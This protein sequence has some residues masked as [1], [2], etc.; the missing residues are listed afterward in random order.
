ML[1]PLVLDCLKPTF[2]RFG[3]HPSA[4]PISDRGSKHGPRCGAELSIPGDALPSAERAFLAASLT[5]ISEGDCCHVCA[6]PI[7]VMRFRSLRS[8]TTNRFNH[9][10]N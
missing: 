4:A 1:N 8:S 5:K 9:F 7:I 6:C 2:N 10:T 3:T